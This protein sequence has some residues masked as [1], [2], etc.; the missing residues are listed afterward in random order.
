MGSQGSGEFQKNISSKSSSLQ[1][2]GLSPYQAE[3]ISS[4]SELSGFADEFAK[5]DS[6]AACPMQSYGWI[7]ACSQSF[8]EDQQC[9]VVLRYA[10]EVVGC[11]AFVR[12]I[13][14]GRLLPLG[15]E[16]FEPT[17]F[18]YADENACE[19][20]LIAVL[21]LNQSIFLRDVYVGLPMAEAVKAGCEGKR[22]CI[23]R[24]MPA[25]PWLRLDQTW[26]D[27]EQH[28]NSGRRSDLRRARR[29]A[30]K[31]GALSFL[32]E[33][34]TA[35]TIAPLMDEVFEVESRNWKGRTGSAMAYTPAIQQFYRTY[36][37][38]AAE[39]GIARVL[40]MRVGDKTVAVQFGVEFNRRFWLLKMGY[41]ETYS[42]CSPGMLLMVES[43]RHATECGLEIYEMM[44]IR[45]AWNQ[46]W[47]EEAHEAVSL[48]IYAPGMRGMLGA[49]SDV[50]RAGLR[51][52]IARTEVTRTAE[53]S[54]QEKK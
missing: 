38:M 16:L 53:K 11:A 43:L 22:I 34:P 10:G 30:E 13:A 46:V 51:K 15:H 32:V 41:D 12:S 20:L 29:Q 31:Q 39:Q 50:V 2:A 47:T 21:E 45:E 40:M 54:G 5:L 27:P 37:R 8:T 42:K 26:L 48:R 49:G 1:T 7:E 6:L 19:E 52:A 33:R 23:E 3:V 24:P 17:I 14:E 4:I 18:A 9:I 35:E 28:L 36:A 44:G 25:H